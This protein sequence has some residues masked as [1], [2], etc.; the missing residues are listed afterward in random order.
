[1]QWTLCRPLRDE[2]DVDA[3]D[4][5]RHVVDAHDAAA[6]HASAAFKVVTLSAA[7]LDWA[8]LRARLAGAMGPLI[9]H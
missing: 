5:D 7:S 8:L 2:H 9:T 1:M 6:T 4:G 3:Q